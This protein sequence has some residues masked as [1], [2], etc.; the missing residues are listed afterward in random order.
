MS[1]NY[2]KA[3]I[4]S[5]AESLA[6]DLREYEDGTS[7]TTADLARIAGYD[8]MDINDLFELDAALYKAA[9]A[10]HIRLDNS[11]HGDMTEGLPFNLDFIV[12]NKK[13]QIK[14][15][16][17]GSI[18]TARYIYGMPA[19]DE[20]MQKMLDSGKWA[21][22]GCC[23]GGFKINGEYISTD[24]TRRC[25]VCKKD[26]GA[27]PILITRKKDTIED[28]RDIVTSVKFSFGEYRGGST[29][30]TIK[31]NDS[32]ATVCVDKLL[33]PR[34]I[35][36]AIPTEF[37]FSKHISPDKWTNIVATLYEQLYLNEWKRSFDDH[38]TDDGKY[39]S[40]TVKLTEGRKRHYSG[41]N[42]YPPYWKELNRLFGNLMRLRNI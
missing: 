35:N 33:S 22:G 41:I 5:I 26:F 29:D 42:A 28:L 13:A 6:E 34:E 23:I 9:R 38:G 14:C 31:K 4:R 1:D 8:D 12:R 11:H 40:L 32:G 7:T 27:A 18:N 36:K 17:C 2:S 10:N 39:W 30:I 37:P 25:N 15:P 3:D 24:P 19:F 16:R 20:H 21:L